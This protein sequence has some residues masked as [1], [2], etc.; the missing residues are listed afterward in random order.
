MAIK[1]PSLTSMNNFGNNEVT[2]RIP[3]QSTTV[4]D[5]LANLSTTIIKNYAPDFSYLVKT[6]FSTTDGKLTTTYA[7]TFSSVTTLES[8]YLSW[9]TPKIFDVHLI[10]G[11]TTEAR[12]YFLNFKAQPFLDKFGLTF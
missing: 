9:V 11:S 3:L 6:T 10:F 5:M 12:D 8:F 4:Y 7:T 1:I 2:V